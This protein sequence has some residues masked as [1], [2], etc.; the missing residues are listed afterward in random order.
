MVC[1]SVCVT[2]QPSLKHA[3]SPCSKQEGHNVIK[4]HIFNINDYDISLQCKLETVCILFALWSVSVALFFL[5]KCISCFQT[6]Y[7]QPKGC[8]V[9]NSFDLSR[10]FLA[11]YNWFTFIRTVKMYVCNRM[12]GQLTMYS[13]TP[14]QA[15][16]K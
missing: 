3:L 13:Q 9:Q 5:R 11:G 4:G 12:I 2:S 14:S 8:I 7:Y 10:V 1:L 16:M 6:V 15:Y